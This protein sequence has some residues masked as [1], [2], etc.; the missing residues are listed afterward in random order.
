[1]A[2]WQDGQRNSEDEKCMKFDECE[3]VYSFEVPPLKLNA[4]INKAGEHDSLGGNKIK[5]IEKIGEWYVVIL[6][7]TNGYPYVINRLKEILEN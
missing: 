5:M 3:D 1:M 7:R 6:T 4:F 2:N